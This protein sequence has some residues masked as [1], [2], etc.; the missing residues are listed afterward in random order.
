[1]SL[2]KL[3]ELMLDKEAWHAAIHGVAESDTTEWLNWTE[4]SSLQEYL[5]NPDL[6]ERFQDWCSRVQDS[7]GS[8]VTEGYHASDLVSGSLV[9]IPFKSACVCAKLLQSCL[10]LC[11]PRTV[12]LQAPLSMG[13]SR[14]EYWSGVPCPPPVDLSNPG[15]DPVSLSSLMFSASASRFLTT[16][17]TRETNSSKEGNTDPTPFFLLEVLR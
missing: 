5:A 3:W 13:F 10:T 12:A 16:N 15:I 8:H 6:A 7:L 17:T 11:N 4:L 14:Q 9:L 2:G 1:M